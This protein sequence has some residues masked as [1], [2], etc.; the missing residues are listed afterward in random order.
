VAI[1]N[2]SLIILGF[3][4]TE[5][6]IQ[7][8]IIEMPIGEKTAKAKSILPSRKAKTVCQRKIETYGISYGLGKRSPALWNRAADLRNGQAEPL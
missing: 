1:V 8:A 5:G 2:S 4:E 3:A 6:R 7:F